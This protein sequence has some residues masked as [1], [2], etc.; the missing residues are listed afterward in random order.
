MTRYDKP[1]M[2]PRALRKPLPII[3]MDMHDC[4]MPLVMTALPFSWCGHVSCLGGN[5]IW[6]ASN[7]QDTMVP[8]ASPLPKTSFRII[9]DPGPDCFL[10]KCMQKSLLR[11]SVSC[12]WSAYCRIVHGST[13]FEPFGCGI[14]VPICS[15]MPFWSPWH[16]YSTPTRP[17]HSLTRNIGLGSRVPL[18]GPLIDPP[19]RGSII[20]VTI[21]VPPMSYIICFMK[22]H[23]IMPWKRRPLYAPTWNPRDCTIMIRLPS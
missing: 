8:M 4:T 12:S 11:I 14:L 1:F 20:A 19:T 16:G 6:P 13:V 7:P 2:A 21:F 3:Y 18:P 5:F 15:L 17:Y 10:P 23:I 22:F 9:F